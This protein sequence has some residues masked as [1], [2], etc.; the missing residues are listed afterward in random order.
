MQHDDS[1]DLLVFSYGAL[2]RREVQEAMFGRAFESRPAHLSGFEVI[3][4]PVPADHHD[5][6]FGTS[7]TRLVL[8]P[9]AHPDS[10]L[11]GQLLALTPEELRIADG[12]EAPEYARQL[13]RIDNEIEA[14]VY[15]PV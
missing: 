8:Q 14:W 6:I 5:P 15:F 10:I 4:V 7:D 12:F 9:S 3:E 13:V 1:T 11:R 2:Q